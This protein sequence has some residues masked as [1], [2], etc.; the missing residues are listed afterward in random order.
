MFECELLFSLTHSLIHS[1]IRLLACSSHHQGYTPL[2]WAALL[3]NRPIAQV[4]I[5]SGA[6]IEDRDSNGDTPLD[7]AVNRGFGSLKDI[8]IDTFT[9]HKHNRAV[10]RCVGLFVCLF[11]FVV[12]SLISEHSGH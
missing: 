6:Q 7:I 8:M 3:G 5:L 10:C 12:C 1:F 2:H 11:V 9:L 4:L